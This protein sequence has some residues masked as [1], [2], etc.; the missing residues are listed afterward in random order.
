ME[1]WWVKGYKNDGKRFNK[2]DKYFNVKPQALRYCEKLIAEGFKF[3][4]FEYNDKLKRYE[5]TTK[6]Y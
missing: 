3:A 2:K 1:R 5:Q 4:L 6:Y